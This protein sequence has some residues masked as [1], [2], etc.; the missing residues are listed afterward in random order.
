MPVTSTLLS[1]ENRLANDNTKYPAFIDA[2]MNELEDAGMLDILS[3]GLQ[4]H[5]TLDPIAQQSVEKALN[6][7]ILC[8]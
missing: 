6:S 1:E 7:N 5:T 2:V 3:E 4:I 8:K